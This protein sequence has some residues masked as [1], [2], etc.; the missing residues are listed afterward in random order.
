[1]RIWLL[2]ERFDT[3]LRRL[4]F[5]QKSVSI[6]TIL[7]LITIRFNKQTFI[8]SGKINNHLKIFARKRFL[9][10]FGIGGAGRPVGRGQFWRVIQ[11]GTQEIIGGVREAHRLALAGPLFEAC[12]GSLPEE[13]CT[14]F[15]EFKET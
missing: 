14:C 13:A 10:K 1:L 2:P 5:A 8:E 3:Q 4:V 11:M 7:F 6:L 12:I 9:R 15:E